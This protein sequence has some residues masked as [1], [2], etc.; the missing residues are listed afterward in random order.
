MAGFGSPFTLVAFFTGAFFL[1]AIMFLPF[2]FWVYGADVAPRRAVSYELFRET[3]SEFERHV[4]ENCS[5]A[6]RQPR[7]SP[8]PPCA[9]FWRA[10]TIVLERIVIPPLGC[11]VDP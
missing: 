11:R 2:G 7:T 8:C 3:A 4:S 6:K 10:A 1:I 5:S 9:L